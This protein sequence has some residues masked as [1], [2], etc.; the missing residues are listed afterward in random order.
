MTQRYVHSRRSSGFTLV[1][2]IAAL[3]LMAIILPVTMRGVSFASHA[4][5]DARRRNEASILAQSKLDELLATQQWAN[6]GAMSG[7]FSGD[8]WPDYSWSAELLSWSPNGMVMDAGL[9]GDALSGNSTTPSASSLNSSSSS[10]SS[11]STISS[12]NNSLQELDVHITWND[13]RGQQSLMLGTLVY[14][15]GNSTSSTSGLSGTTFP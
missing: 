10:S 8:G 12:A 7:D 2:V 1:E 13:N 14:Q 9:G 6:G 4:A 11:N 5:V 3:L 15:S